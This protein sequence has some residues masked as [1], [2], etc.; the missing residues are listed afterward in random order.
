M[1]PEGHEILVVVNDAVCRE[2]I[3]RILRDEGFAVT[4]AAAGLAALRA[5][6]ARRFTLVIAGTGLPGSLDGRTTVRQARIRQPWLKA[7]F[8]EDHHESRSSPPNR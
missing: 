2:R 6:S 3:V 1:Y 5:M 7:L 4:E 8:I